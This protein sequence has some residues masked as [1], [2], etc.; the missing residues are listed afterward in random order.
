[1][2]WHRQVAQ[3]VAQPE[4]PRDAVDTSGAPVIEMRKVTKRYVMGEA[5]EHRKQTGTADH[6]PVEPLTVH[7]LRGID[8][9]VERGE[10]VAIMGASGSGKSTLMNII[11]ALDAPTSGAYR[12][13]GLDVSVLDAH[14]LA[15][16][17]N[18]KIGFVFQSFNLIAR[19]TAFENVE[20]PLVY[21][22]LGAGE[23]R[24]RTLAA[25]DAVG[26][27]DRAD[28]MPSQLSGGQQQRVAIARAIVTSPALLLAD[29]P[30]GALDSHTTEEVLDLFARIN[31]LGR[32]VVII[33]HEADVAARASRVITLRDGSIVTDTMTAPAGVTSWARSGVASG[34]TS[35]VTA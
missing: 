35:G 20:L 12:L 11:G 10:F 18:R 4:R 21:A 3:P 2:K 22:K 1:M 24:S 6:E 9:R 15:K 34:V 29:E 31:R 7:A 32:T 16:A 27:A 28:H 33:T 5:K 17:R 14:Q 25:L 19:T 30:T 23:R 26:L 13:D 8:L